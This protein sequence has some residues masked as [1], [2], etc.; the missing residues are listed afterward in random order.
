MH[1]AEGLSSPFGIYLNL[2]LTPVPQE[3][4]KRIIV[5]RHSLCDMLSS[6]PSLNWHRN[7]SFNLQ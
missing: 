7:R 5:G 3:D 2:L 1:A 6:D 4:T